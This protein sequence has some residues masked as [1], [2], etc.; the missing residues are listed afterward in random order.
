[1]AFL[2]LLPLGWSRQRHNHR[3]WYSGNQF[4]DGGDDNDTIAVTNA[5]ELQLSLGSGAG[6]NIGVVSRALFG[7]VGNDTIKVTGTG[8]TSAS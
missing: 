8:V 7:E 6:I 1:M 5:A 2:V 4:L 3:C